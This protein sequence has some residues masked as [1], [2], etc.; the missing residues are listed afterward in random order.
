MGIYLLA[1]PF[2]SG[3]F[4]LGLRSNQPGPGLDGARWRCGTDDPSS[5]GDPT[6]A[7]ELGGAGIRE[8]PLFGQLRAHP[9]SMEFAAQQV[10]GELPDADT[11]PMRRRPSAVKKHSTVFVYTENTRAVRSAGQASSAQ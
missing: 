1:F 3:S 5:L 2:I 9:D 6:D 10:V 8:F 11:L 7:G 4:R